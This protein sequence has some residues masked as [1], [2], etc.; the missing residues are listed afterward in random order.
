MG[1][2]EIHTW[3]SRADDVEH[4]DRVVFDLDP[5]PSVGWPAV[6]EAARLLRSR[7]ADLDLESYVKTTGGKG[8]HVVVPLLPKS[9][10]SETFA[11]TRALSERL[12][13]EQPER[14]TTEMPKARRKGKILV[15][16]L[17]NNRGN[18][19]VAAYSTRARAQAPL[20][21]PLR[22]DELSR[23]APDQF[24]VANLPRRLAALKG[25][26]WAGYFEARQRL[27]PAAKRALGI[28]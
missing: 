8:L 25:D 19:S 21:T 17:R 11:L 6:V 26:P 20:S 12:E 10:W 16:Y 18:T 3:N 2:L 24:T 14:Y 27:T 13:R 4:P 7:L 28:G 1:I 5:D 9:D 15:D 22:W 23:V